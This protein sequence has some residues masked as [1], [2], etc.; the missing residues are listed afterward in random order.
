VALLLE[1][2]AD[3][4]QRGINDY[5]ALHMAVGERNLDAVRVLLAAG[6]DPRLKTRIDDY[7]TPGSLADRIGF[8]DAAAL[9]AAAADAAR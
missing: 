2:G 9:L 5:T 3:P 4:D 6:A 8:R 7:E 1:F